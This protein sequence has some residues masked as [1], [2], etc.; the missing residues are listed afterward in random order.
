[1]DTGTELVL[2]G[3][4]RG[5]TVA[6]AFL[7]R[8]TKVGWVRQ[9][10]FSSLKNIVFLQYGAEQECSGYIFFPGVRFAGSTCLVSRVIAVSVPLTVAGH[11]R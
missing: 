9:I 4:G 5:T 7:M 2:G 6:R 11:Q 1:M 8:G 3:P 10:D